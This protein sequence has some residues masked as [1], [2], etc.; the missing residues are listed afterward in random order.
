[1]SVP[2]RRIKQ[3]SFS[4]PGGSYSIAREKP[5]QANFSVTGVPRNRKLSGES[6]G[7]ASATGLDSLTLDDVRSPA[8]ATPA[9]T[10]RASFTTFDGL[11]I[12]ATGHA[13]GDRRYVIF[14]AK[15]STKDQEHEADTLQR[16]FVGHEF[17]IP[18]YK[19][20][21]IFRPLDDLLEKPTEP[22]ATAPTAGPPPAAP[23]AGAQ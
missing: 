9:E 1:M 23:S 5:E 22:Q 12:D 18:P 8:G 13:E 20:N 19:Y 15:S 2:E 21:A 6:A 7:N 11:R 16:R 17:E 10:A 3:A 14:S 4:G